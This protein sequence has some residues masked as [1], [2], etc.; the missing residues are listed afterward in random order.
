MRGKS[1]LC[2]FAAVAIALLSA[3]GA[4]AQSEGSWYPL[5]ADDGTDIVN[6]RVPVEPDRG[7]AWNRNRRKPAWRRDAGGILRSQLSILPQS[8]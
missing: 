4:G 6:Y 8:R 1:V 3:V 5:K 7:A 2:F